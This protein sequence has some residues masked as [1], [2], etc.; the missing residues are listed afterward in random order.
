MISTINLMAPSADASWLG[1]GV[2]ARPRPVNGALSNGALPNGAL[3]NGDGVRPVAV[4]V[5][6]D[7][8]GSVTPVGFAA[9]LPMAYGA[10]PV[11]T[12][13]GAPGSRTGQ[14]ANLSQTSTARTTKH[15][16]RHRFRHWSPPN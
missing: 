14:T 2:V 1:S 6:C 15:L 3:P 5:L 16:P 11:T 8:S 4:E 13:L 9:A 10:L 7:R 12:V